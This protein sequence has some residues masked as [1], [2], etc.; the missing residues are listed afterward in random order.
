MEWLWREL[1]IVSYLR[2]RSQSAV[3]A[4]VLF[5][6]YSLF[7]DRFVVF[8][9]D[10]QPFSIQTDQDKQK[11]R[12]TMNSSISDELREA[13]SQLTSVNFITAIT[14]FFIVTY[15][16]SPYTRVKLLTITFPNGYPS[17]PP[18]LKKKIER[19]LN[20]LVMDTDGRDK[21]KFDQ[22]HLVPQHLCHS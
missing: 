21:I 7:S 13:K 17:H 2:F 15:E 20:C 12:M 4:R 18:G 6:F 3:S 9:I 10:F 22:V 14:A 1:H 5:S 16:G 11:Q 19:E 8:R